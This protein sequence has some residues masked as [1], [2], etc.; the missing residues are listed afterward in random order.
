MHTISGCPATY[1]KGNQICFAGKQP[2]HLCSTLKQI[3]KE[4][5]LT[6]KWRD[7]KCYKQDNDYGYVKV[8]A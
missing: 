7:S 5:K 3:I 1:V 8:V 6:Y 4:R 2:I